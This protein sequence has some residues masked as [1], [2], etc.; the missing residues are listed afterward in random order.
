[1]CDYILNSGSS[2][3]LSELKNLRL[4]FGAL[5]GPSVAPLP[6]A[7]AAFRALLDPTL[8][9]LLLEDARDLERPLG[10]FVGACGRRLSAWE[11]TSDSSTCKYTEEL[12]SLWAVT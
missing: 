4:F 2:S 12:H 5:G 9:T 7:G 6:L 10:R 3:S 1:M 11:A 8:A